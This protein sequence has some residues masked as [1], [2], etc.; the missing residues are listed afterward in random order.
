[1]NSHYFL[2]L[3]LL[4]LFVFELFCEYFSMLG[5]LNVYIINFSHSS[6]L[7]KYFRLNIS[8]Q[9]TD[10]GYISLV[11][12]CDVCHSYFLISKSIQRC[13]DPVFNVV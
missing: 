3:Y 2:L 5:E 1:M 8:L 9:N 4:Y 6:T 12:I 10:F 11:L 7:Y 13:I